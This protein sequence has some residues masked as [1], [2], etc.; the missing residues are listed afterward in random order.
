[1]QSKSENACQH[2]FLKKYQYKHLSFLNRQPFSEL[3]N[4]YFKYISS[5]HSLKKCKTILKPTIKSNYA[6]QRACWIKDQNINIFNIFIALFVFFL[7]NLSFHLFSYPLL[8]EELKDVTS[9][10][11]GFHD[12]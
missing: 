5:F 4:A 3:K 2:C 9:L 7:V 1:M 12:F 11:S 8:H 10:S 6:L